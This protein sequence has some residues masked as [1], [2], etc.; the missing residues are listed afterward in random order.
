[1]QNSTTSHERKKRK[2]KK[3]TPTTHPESDVCHRP[4]RHKLSIDLGFLILSRSRLSCSSFGCR[5]G[6]RCSGR[7]SRL[8][9]GAEIRLV[10]QRTAG[11]AHAGGGLGSRNSGR[12][13]LSSGSRYISCLRFG[14]LWLSGG[15]SCGLLGGGGSRWGRGNSSYRLGG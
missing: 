1:M 5:R 15:R 2:E 13:F 12:S 10:R 8:F 6:G 9:R 14:G 4:P 7:C 11:S 3:S